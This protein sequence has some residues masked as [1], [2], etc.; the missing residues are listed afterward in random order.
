M[1][2]PNIQVSIATQWDK[3][4]ILNQ[5]EDEGFELVHQEKITDRKIVLVFRRVQPILQPSYDFIRRRPLSVNS[6]PINVFNHEPLFTG[7]NAR[8]SPEPSP[9]EFQIA[10]TAQ[11]EA[12]EKM[13][14]F[15]LEDYHPEEPEVDDIELFET[16]MAETDEDT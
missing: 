4:D 6:E 10:N 5:K 3:I 9:K 15:I 16:P 14:Q 1:W 8:Q 11:E 12:K 13:V 7:L 2:D